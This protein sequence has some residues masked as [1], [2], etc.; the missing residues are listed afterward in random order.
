LE[1]M[2]KNSAQITL[3]ALIVVFVVIAI[4]VLLFNLNWGRFTIARETGEAGE[5]KVAGEL[6][7]NGINL[8]YY[9]GD[10]FTV[11]IPREVLNY[12]WLKSPAGAGL[13]EIRVDKTQRAVVLV[14]KLR[15]GG[16]ARV[17]VPIIIDRVRRED[18]TQDYP[19]T[20]IRN[21]KGVIVIHVGEENLKVV[22]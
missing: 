16:E 17:S 13:V 12:S 5:V 19:E 1:E 8:A 20:T 2:R 18:P 14:K 10:G 6:L 21:D 4:A 3:E 9:S 11:F 22:E 7:A 15:T